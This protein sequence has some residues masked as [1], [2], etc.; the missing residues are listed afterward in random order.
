MNNIPYG[1]ERRGGGS[2]QHKGREGA[3]TPFENQLYK[4][5]VKKILCLR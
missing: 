3:C 4:I 1:A 5:N 2:T